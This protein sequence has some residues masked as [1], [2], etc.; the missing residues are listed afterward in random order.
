MLETYTTRVSICIP[1]YN[2]ATTIGETLNSILSQTYQDLEIL[3]VDNASEDNT[4]KVAQEFVDPRIRIYENETNLGGEGNFNR[5]I[6]L[7]K[8]E[9][10]AI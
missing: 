8:G 3:V 2:S 7:A 6:A 4:V 5:C 1:T 10:I 9:Y